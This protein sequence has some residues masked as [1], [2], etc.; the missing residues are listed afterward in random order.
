MQGC[1]DMVM[2]NDVLVYL[3][4]VQL[5]DYLNELEIVS[6]NNKVCIEVG[7]VNY[8]IGESSLI[9]FVF[10]VEVFSELI[11]DFF[12]GFFQIIEEVYEVF[13]IIVEFFG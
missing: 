10:E 12:V 11:F 9:F 2:E 6:N 7:L 1:Q 3:D 8:N 5:V 4:D 13:V